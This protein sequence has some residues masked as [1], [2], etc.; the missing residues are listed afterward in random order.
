[1]NRSIASFL[2][3]LSRISPRRPRTPKPTR[4]APR[5]C[6][7]ALEQRELLSGNSWTDLTKKAPTNIGQNL[8]LLSDGT[9]LARQA[10]CTT[11]WY[12]LTPQAVT[13]DYA[14]G[15][16]SALSSM[17]LMQGTFINTVVVG[18]AA[19]T[20][21]T[22]Q[23]AAAVNFAAAI[24]NSLA[25]NDQGADATVARTYTITG[26]TLDRTGAAEISVSGLSSGTTVLIAAGGGNTINVQGNPG[27]L[28][29]NAGTGSNTINVGTPDNRVDGIGTVSV[30]GQ[31]GLNLLRVNDQGTT[32]AQTYTLQ[33]SLPSVLRSGMYL[34]YANMTGLVLNTGSGGNTID[35]IG[36]LA[37]TPV[38]VNAGAGTDAVNIGSA[39]NSLDAIQGSVT[40]SGNGRTTLTLNDQGTTDREEYDVHSTQITREPI[41]SPPTS[42]TQTVTYSDLSGITLNGGDGSGD[43]Y[44][45][46]GTPAGTSVSLNAGN[47]G[48]NQFLAFDEFSPTDAPPAT[49]Y[50]L[51]PV[52]F[53]GH[54]ASDFGER[55]DSFDA[56]GHTFTLSAVGAV[57][58][59]QR[60]GA[61]DL[62]YDGL[63]QMIMVVAPV[64]GNHVNVQSVA[65]ACT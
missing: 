8:M 30:T 62:T 10:G 54:H 24:S 4:P 38:T 44:F 64:G 17:N 43:Q 21:D 55:V 14:H 16:W 58:T 60:D 63:S 35:V 18:S 42:P 34:V 65:P 2:S 47:G 5:L 27:G 3:R 50:L 1:M 31:G 23:G 51:G 40:V 6:L 9:V 29:V 37:G 53:H 45:A 32:T 49:D 46:L 57:S 61:A 48:F 25:V 36:T 56:A 20:L 11:N 33:T 59:V 7:E 19:N 12:R 15:T 22:I 39:A 28:A 52:A 41:T 26:T 13:E